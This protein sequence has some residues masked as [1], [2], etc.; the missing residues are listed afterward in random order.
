MELTPAI[1]VLETMVVAAALIDWRTSRL[2]NW[3]TIG[4]LGAGLALG[5]LP[6]GI[7]LADATLGA[8]SALALLLPLWLLRATG[9]GDVKLLAAAGAFTGVPGV[10]H[11]LLFTMLLH[12][13]RKRASGTY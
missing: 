11:V 9:A 6:G 7:G 3:L 2:P 1:V 5:A 10:F 8:A 13:G 4:G 12:I